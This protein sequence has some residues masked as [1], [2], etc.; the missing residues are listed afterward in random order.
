MIGTPSQP[1]RDM[2]NFFDVQTS[3][4]HK[5]MSHLLARNSK[6]IFK[7]IWLWLIPLALIMSHISSRAEKQGFGLLS[8][9][10]RLS[11]HLIFKFVNNLLT[12]YMTGPTLRSDS[13]CFVLLGPLLD[14]ITPCCCSLCRFCWIVYLFHVIQCCCQIYFWLNLNLCVKIVSA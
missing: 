9:G 14:I 2:N 8:F 6:S 4:K 10:P 7:N 12:N 5:N 3:V 11:C 1:C 13:Q